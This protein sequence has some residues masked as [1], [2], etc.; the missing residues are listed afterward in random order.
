M[1]ISVSAAAIPEE[2]RRWT[3]ELWIVLTAVWVAG[4]F[5]TRQTARRQTL[6]SRI[7]QI[8]IVLLGCWLLFG[9]GT[10]I[11]WMDAAAFPVTTPVAIAGLATTL[12]GVAFAI[13]A[14][15][16]LGANWSGVITVK[17]GHTLVRRGPYRI[18]RHPIYTG[19]L[20][21]LAGTALTLGPVRGFLAVPVCGFGFWLKMLMEER[22]MLEAFGEEY[23]RYRH[24]VRALV[25]FLF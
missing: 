24:E 22:F 21:A 9:R 19:L 10:G 3:L 14:R 15:V 4:M 23:S 2:A 8:G 25:P 16:T 11:A 12:S 7:W 6:N 20:I 18:V 5:M 1:A 17:E 13:W